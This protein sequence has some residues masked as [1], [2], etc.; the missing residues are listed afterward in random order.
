[1]H[2][3]NFAVGTSGLTTS[4]PHLGLKFMLVWA[5]VAL[6]IVIWGISGKRNL[7]GSA[8]IDR[9]VQDNTN[10]HATKTQPVLLWWLF[11]LF[12]LFYAWLI[13]YGTNFT[14]HDNNQLT[15]FSVR[16]LKFSPPIWG[17][18][19]FFP[20]AH[21]EFNVARY[22]T[23]SC[24]G[25]H[26]LGVA[27]LL[28]TLAI[29]YRLLDDL[30]VHQRLLI[31]FTTLLAPSILISFFG[32]IYPERN[33]II[34][35][36][37]MLFCVRKYAQAGTRLSLILGLLAVHAALYYKEPTFALIVCFAAGRILISWQ[38]RST[39]TLRTLKQTLSELRFEVA[40]LLVTAVF[41]ALFAWMMFPR[42][43]LGY[44][45][46]N[47]SHARTGVLSVLIAYLRVDILLVVL[48]VVVLVRIFKILRH[49]DLA[50]PLWD[51]LAFGALAYAA[52]YMVLQLYAPYYLAPVD[53]IGIL[54]L[55]RL[56]FSN[57]RRSHVAALLCL[58]VITQNLLGAVYHL[59]ERKNIMQ[60]KHRTAE[61]IK[62]TVKQEG[63]KPTRIYFPN[64]EGYQI[65]EF[66]AYLSYLGVNIGEKDGSADANNGSVIFE[67]PRD[68]SR[69]SCVDFRSQ[70]VC[71]HVPSPSPGEL[72]AYLPDDPPPIDSPAISAR[73][74]STL[75]QYVP[76]AVS[77][78]L[79]PM[80]SALR[81][82]SLVFSDKPLP[83]NWLTARVVLAG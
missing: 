52:A 9:T 78:E 24:G 79:R 21:Q 3:F 60:A 20:L 75:F 70:I 42:A 30:S 11:G 66:A 53:L 55:G 41:A 13:F 72:V 64:A 71:H 7:A 76:F 58:V 57:P 29:I 82:F 31:L 67:S 15:L 1:M 2:P 74:M 59:V 14:D 68:F 36:V 73:P 50:E 37:V 40:I 25:Y 69:G 47:R 56:F 33:L 16:G 12:V 49:P 48:A 34:A 45:E 5:F 63:Y 39:R 38:L 19:R 77:T 23:K 6:A 28:I 22:L 83:K 81:G 4:N 32:L 61:F 62:D 80:Y 10:S 46:A 54:Y 18:G 26:V 44:A 65:M 51:P 35:L 8:V 43:S 27:Q 17:D